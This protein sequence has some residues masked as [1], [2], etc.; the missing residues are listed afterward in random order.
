MYLGAFSEI[1]GVDYTELL[2]KLNTATSYITIASKVEKDKIDALRNWMEENEVYSGIN[3]D[4]SIKRY[5]PYNNLASQVIGFTG[6]DNNG[7]VGLENSLENTLAGTA[8]QV[9]TLT[10]SVNDE[11]PNQQKSYIEPKN[12]SN[13]Y[14]TIDVNIQSI[15]EKYLSQ[16]V[17]ENKADYRNGNHYGTIYWEYFSNE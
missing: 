13:I 16:A 8:G 7:L 12:G 5:Y 3:I 9:V 4:S 11:I 6:T 14:L 2:E 17:I 15:A 1:F 10:D